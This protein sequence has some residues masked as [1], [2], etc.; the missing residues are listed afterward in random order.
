VSEVRAVTVA[1]NGDI[2]ITENDYGFIRR[3]LKR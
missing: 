3:V 2:L 1:P